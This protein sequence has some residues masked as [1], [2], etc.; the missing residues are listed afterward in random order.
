MEVSGHL[1]APAA[2]PPGKEPIVPLDRELGGLQSWSG[3]C[4]KEKYSQPLPVLETLI[5]QPIAEPYI[6]KLSH[7]L[8]IFYEAL[9]FQDTQISTWPSL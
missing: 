3:H 8:L 6:T 4:G 1:H 7:L 5:I 9:Q 2:L